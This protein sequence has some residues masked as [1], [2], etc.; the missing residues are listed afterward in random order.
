MEGAGGRAPAAG[1]AGSAGRMPG[2]AAACAWGARRGRPPRARARRSRRTA[3]PRPLAP[4]TRHGRS[5]GDEGAED[6][7]LGPGGEGRRKG[8]GC[9]RGAA[10]RRLTPAHCCTQT[11]PPAPVPP[12]PV[13]PA[14]VPPAPV[15]PAPAPHLAPRHGLGRRGAHEGGGAGRCAGL[16][17]AGAQTRARHGSGSSGARR[18]RV[19]RA[20][21][22][23]ARRG[24]HRVWPTV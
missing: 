3:A 9:A 8:T 24:A 1:A 4:R 18:A 19:G 12:A 16:R 23:G 7:A 14:P 2:F 17:P 11:G 6:G 15:P 10:T 13:P 22:A 5:I 20:A 21:H